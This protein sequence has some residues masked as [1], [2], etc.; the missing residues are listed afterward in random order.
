MSELQ[1]I[2]E[3][4]FEFLMNLHPAQIK[5][6]NNE[7]LRPLYRLASKKEEPVVSP[8]IE[9]HKQTIHELESEVEGLKK[10]LATTKEIMHS[11]QKIINQFLNSK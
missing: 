7:I 4:A 1:P 9:L 6:L 5:K 10:E 8:E 2:K 11:K 3:K